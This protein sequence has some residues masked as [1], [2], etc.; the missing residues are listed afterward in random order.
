[1]FKFAALSAILG[2][3]VS[4]SE[5]YLL[6]F[7]D[8]I[9]DIGN[10]RISASPIPYYS[11]RFCNGPVWNEYLSHT[12]GFTLI[13]YAFGGA[14][15]N[16]SFVECITGTNTTVPS[17]I[18]QITM[19][20]QT[21][22]GKFPVNSTRDDVVVIEIGTNDFITAAGDLIT[23]SVD[24]DQFAD[25]IVQNIIDGVSI[26]YNIGYRK[27]VVTDIPDFSVTPF[28]RSF[29][30]K[31]SDNLEPY[32]VL[33]NKR[34]AAKLAVLENSYKKD[35]DYIR[36]FEFYRAL[37]IVIENATISALNI[38]VA[39]EP[40]YVVENGTLVSS[41]ENSDKYLFVDSI[42]P[43]TKVHAL[44]AAAFSK[45]LDNRNFTIT[46]TGMWSLIDSY[47]L[48]LVGSNSN[49]LYKDFTNKNQ[50][51]VT[52]YNIYQ[53]IAESAQI[54]DAKLCEVTATSTSS[55]HTHQIKC[56]TL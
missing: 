48:R 18:D 40:C 23:E 17:V 19:F 31:T 47:E 50:L 20:N 16:K 30:Q 53:A 49:W 35:I 14:S 54:I 2:L 56:K 24:L 43:S 32:I 6:V 36:V 25:G 45:T 10:T 22:G 41:C 29:P 8:S 7:G 55:H 33:T 52:E 12:N 27:I 42:H 15:S 4:A 46:K 44:I 21:F 11:G 38:T 37:K 26:L 1:M 9:S 5:N 34:L 39:D 13:N 28:F 3:A 51:I